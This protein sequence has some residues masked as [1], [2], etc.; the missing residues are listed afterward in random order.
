M[1][2]SI[3]KLLGI[4]NASRLCLMPTNP[5][6]AAVTSQRD[7]NHTVTPAVTLS[8]LVSWSDSIM[9]VSFFS[10]P[11]IFGFHLDGQHTIK[12]R[13]TNSSA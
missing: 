8:P 12:M 13:S 10:A 5:R 11:Q 1:T 7:K 2:L 4:S 6:V 3:E 9:Y